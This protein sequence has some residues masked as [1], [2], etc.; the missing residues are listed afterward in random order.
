MSKPP[1]NKPYAEVIG[2]P[3]A[4]SKS[5]V[6]H[7]F[8]L[9]KLGIDADYRACHVRPHDLEDYF[10]QRRADPD[11]RGC[12]VTIP[13]KQAVLP[14]LDRQDERAQ[15][16]GAVNTVW[17]ASDGRLCGTNTDV[18][19]VREAVGAERLAGGRAVVIGAGGAARAA[20][21]LLA[22]RDS[23]ET[24]VLAR[25][26]EK[27][28]SAVTECGL[29]ARILPFT[30]D[31][32]ALDGA[33]VL[34]NATQLGMTK[35]DGMPSFLLEEIAHMAKGALVFDM[36]YAPLETALL[37]TA[38]DLGLSTSD[39]LVMLVGQAAKAFQSFF[40]VAPV[41]GDDDELRR[42]LMS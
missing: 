35:Q 39:G 7:N 14:F 18:D 3:I 31:S 38:R 32:G 23:I 17:P 33:T 8:W 36:V 42:I 25:S 1:G 34:I 15:R 29:N 6:I 9:E 22:E 19:G 12:N 27:A 2:D 21:A 4:H 20:F 16:V 28:K 10:K 37:N 40:G 41:R 13:H 24:A 5:P 11:W 26:P 30:A